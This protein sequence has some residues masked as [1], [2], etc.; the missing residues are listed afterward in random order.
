MY[1]SIVTE[2]IWKDLVAELA[3]RQ[4]PVCVT[5]LTG[6][7]KAQI[8]SELGHRWTLYIAPDEKEASGVQSDLMTFQS[9]VWL[10][11]ARD[12]LFYSSD[13]HGNFIRN[14]RADARRHLME[15]ASGV[16]VTTIDAL[17]D[18]IPSRD[19][20]RTTRCRLREGLIVSVEELSKILTSMGYERSWQIEAMGQFAVRGGIVDIFPVTEEFPVR[21][22]FFDDEIDTI[23][24]FDPETQRSS[25]RR[26]SIEIYPASEGKGGDV[27][28]LDYFGKD[29][30]IVAEN[31]VRLKTKAEL[32]EA[33][34]R[35]AVLRRKDKR[36]HADL[37]KRSRGRETETPVSQE[38]EEVIDIFPAREIMER[39]ASPGTLYLAALDDTLKEFG[40]KCAFHFNT[41]S[42]RVFRE[43]AE[44]MAEEM[45]HYEK[46]LYRITVMTP[47]RTRT[48]RLAESLR[49]LGFKAY[50]PD[51]HS[52][53][54]Q[55]GC[56]EVV[57][58]TLR[59]GFAC[60]DIR[61]ILFTESDMYGKKKSVK[62]RK[63]NVPK[64]E[65]LSSLEELSVGDYVV[66]ESHGIG[67]YKG[68]SRIERDDT[69]R[70]YIHIEYADGGSLFLPATR[71]D[72][73][74]KYAGAEG[75][76]PKV[77]KLNSGEWQK[78]RERVNKAVG[79]LAR[80]L[81]ELYAKR[82]VLS[83]HR[84]GPDTVWQREFE[85]LFPFE[86]TEDQQNAI[87]AVK[88]DMESGRIMDRLVCGDVG[89]GK[90]EIALR[91]AFKAVQEGKQ[92][93]Y[94]VPTT[95][96][97]KQ[98]YRTFT[99]RMKNFPVKVEMMCRFRS[100]AEN[101][102]TEE[103]LRTG[104]VDI[105][106]GTHRILSGNVKFKDLGL[107]IID[108]EQRFGVAHKEKIK[109]M[110][111]DVD[112]LVLTATPIPR[113]LHM[114]LTGIRDLSLL[115]EPPFDRIP[116]QTYVMEY[117]DE[118]VREAIS[119]EVARNGQVYYV[120]NRV[121]G[122]EEKVDRLRSLLPDVRIE[123]A[124]GQMNEHE[125]ENIMMDFVEGNIDVLVS[126]TIIETGL[127]IPNAN[128]LIVDGAERLGLAQLYQI[129]GRVGRSNRTSYAFL[130]YRKDKVLSEEAEKRLKAIRE[131]TEFGSG[132]KIAMRDLEIR[133]A[134]NVLG[135]EQSGQMEAVGY[136]LYCKLL[137]K[138]VRM[139]SGVQEKTEEFNTV[140]D[141][142]ID[143]FIPEDY[144]RSEYQKLDIYKR[145]AGITDEEQFM[146]MQDE[147]VD[148]FGDI[149]E[150][151]MNLL[152]IALVK[153]QAHAAYVT[154]LN[155]RRDGFEMVMWPKAEINVDA[156][157][158]LIAAE[159]G[160]LRLVRG[161][162]PSFEYQD[163]RTVHPDAGFML[164]K[165]AE[166]IKAITKV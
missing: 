104:L 5:G 41:A 164:D 140:I 71:L 30:L 37:D 59:E 81:V 28:L 137:K 19:R 102:K 80:E 115:E 78:T 77:N 158:D 156:I 142:D 55:P 107:L 91:A 60:P 36:L 50:C 56:V 112:V 24:P 58:G 166:L 21:V 38:E 2:P 143:A 146:D 149:P 124:H 163:D 131:F 53:E 127:D 66:H 39:L 51:E 23:R 122:I 79:E 111:A 82:S 133:G 4:A 108:E 109:K 155:I 151:V 86:E 128:T 47:S 16:L 147:L 72:L 85:E 3:L 22:E 40:A 44:L 113:T 97:A 98:H 96:L 48:V 159:K 134:G 46:E 99:E 49:E 8:T 92:V 74:Q 12:L 63:K 70:D 125:L 117:D 84:C 18:K 103:L 148:R 17:M 43:N 139:L 89:Y 93:A 69:V 138:A 152:R 160:K 11:P 76:K 110:K 25:G 162:V 136:E 126:T 150:E 118:M 64:G 27:S 132:I 106:I 20:V 165:A 26:E 144:I 15:D 32:T 14:Q 119:R 94:L 101:K 90:T 157:P 52:G 129:R 130:M 87:D 161:S 29:D 35:E 114:S 7:R 75:R 100:S 10:Y 116:I 95:I 120:F 1:N 31:P 83:G 33:E 65:K 123:Y 54:L 6:S 68:I 61:Y 67:V 62:H 154:E 88:R 73:V 135:A 45:H 121:N 105:V 153:A 13:I 57:H 141:C 42:A 9:N 34:F 145:I